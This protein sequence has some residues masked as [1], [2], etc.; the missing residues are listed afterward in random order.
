MNG[1]WELEILFLMV[2][3]DISH[4]FLVF[5]S[6]NYHKSARWNIVHSCSCTV[7][8]VWSPLYINHPL[9]FMFVFKDNEQGIFF[10]AIDICSIPLISFIFYTNR[11][12]W[13]N[14][15]R[16]NS[17][18]ISFKKNTSSK[19]GTEKIH[20]AHAG[21]QVCLS[22]VLSKLLKSLFKIPKTS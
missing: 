22:T 6:L 13:Q 1:K 12:F 17:N 18:D 7:N 16:L 10:I 8:I 9:Q 2:M 4:S 15:M 19:G 20:L 14:R 5:F 21:W 3:N 11:I